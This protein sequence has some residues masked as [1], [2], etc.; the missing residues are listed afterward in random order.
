[1]KKVYQL[2][3]AISFSLV[4]IGAV[5]QSS[6]NIR[7]QTGNHAQSTKVGKF[8]PKRPMGTPTTI[9]LNYDSA[10]ATIWEGLGTTYY[11]NQG[12]LTNVHY[13]HKDSINNADVINYAT[14]AFDS[15][16]D[17]YNSLAA[18]TAASV[19]VDTIYVPFVHNNASGIA[20]TLEIQL[21]SVNANGYPMASI[22][23]DTMIISTTLG[24][25]NSSSQ[26]NFASL[27]FNYN[28]VGSSKFAVTLKYHGAKNDSCWFIYGFGS[29]SGLCQ[30][31]GPY[32]LADSTNFSTVKGKTSG[33]F[34]ANSFLY[35]ANQQAGVPY[36][37][38][39]S[40]S[41]GGIF[42]DCNSDGKLD[43]G[44]GYSYY[45]NV[46]I[47][48]MVTFTPTGI[49]N[50][51]ANGFDVAQNYPNPF[52]KTTQINYNVTKSSDVVFT[53]FD[54]MGRKLV[55]NAFTEVAP[56]QHT[57]NLSANQFTPG[58]YFYTFNVNGKS[59]T[60]K[61]VITE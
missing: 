22:L 20:D 26:I 43:A 57:I 12:E 16:V 34:T 21:N 51:T 61:M 11:H 17:P 6:D 54:M 44:D 23:K 18:Y 37:I 53:V 50:L 10:D 41:G 27:G 36:G 55:N 8:N 25:V 42:Y 24:G 48:A 28:V 49:N 5:A 33:K 40:T 38:L 4:S 60:K 47:F 32:T 1:M 45:E 58:V 35:W 14:V 7:F 39:P 52:N 56:G 29:F 3:A 19:M 2:V 15:L 13:T 30:G 46:N 59:V 9:I 31:G